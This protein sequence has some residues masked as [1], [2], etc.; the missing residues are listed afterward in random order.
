M[1]DWLNTSGDW[2]TILASAESRYGEMLRAAEWDRRL[3]RQGNAPGGRRLQV[4]L[5][6]TVIL[7]GMIAW[8][9]R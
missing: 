9:G 7:L 5:T 2:K 4:I 8:W 6:L 3:A 1:N